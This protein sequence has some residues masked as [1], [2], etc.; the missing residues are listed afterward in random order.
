M[1]SVNGNNSSD[2][3]FGCGILIS[4]KELVGDCSTDETCAEALN[5]NGRCLSIGGKLLCL[6]GS[7]ATDVRLEYDDN[8][9]LLNDKIEMELDESLSII[10]CRASLLLARR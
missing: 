3:L 8:D 9:P 6:I 4:A 1:D 10:D 7:S 5:A 2:P